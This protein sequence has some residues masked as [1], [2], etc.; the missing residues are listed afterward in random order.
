MKTI[1]RNAKPAFSETYVIILF[2]FLIIASYILATQSPA[3]AQSG[4]ANQSDSKEG[5]DTKEAGA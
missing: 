1:T 5:S 3:M 4:L 2:L